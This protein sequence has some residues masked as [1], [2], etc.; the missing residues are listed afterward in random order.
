MRLEEKMRDFEKL[1]RESDVDF[2]LACR[3][4]GEYDKY[5]MLV[6][7]VWDEEGREFC[8]SDAWDRLESLLESAA[9]WVHKANVETYGF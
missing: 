2:S 8:E 4:E 6:L 5:P 7:T 9:E 1:A 3:Y